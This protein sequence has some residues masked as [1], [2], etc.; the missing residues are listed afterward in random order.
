MLRERTQLCRTERLGKFSESLSGGIAYCI[1]RLPAI[2]RY[3]GGFCWDSALSVGLPGEKY[4][5]SND[6][7]EESTSCE[8]GK[9][10]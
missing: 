10:G 6:K 4:R 8:A 2:M 1:R 7:L 9:R 3:A 5:F